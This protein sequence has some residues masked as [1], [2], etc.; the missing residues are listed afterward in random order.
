MRETDEEYL[1]RRISPRE[2]LSVLTMFP[3]YFEIETVNAC[4][5]RCPMCTIADWN[6]KDGAMK[7]N[8]FEKIAGEIE[9]HPEVLRVS[10]FRD[11]EPLLDKKLGKRI[12][13]IKRHSLADVQICTN[14]ELLD[15]KRGLEILQAGLDEC[16]LSIDSTRAATY[17]K[18]RVGLDH[19]KVM[20]NSHRFFQLRDGLRSKC[21]IRVRMI[22]QPLNA[23]EWEARFRSEWWHRLKPGDTVE[24][25]D[26]HNWGGQLHG[27]HPS[28][29]EQGE[30]GGRVPP[31]IALWSLMTIFANGDVPLC[32]VDYNNKFPLGNVRDTSIAELWQSASQNNRRRVHWD[33]HREILPPCTNC[34][35]WSEN[36][37]APAIQGHAA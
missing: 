2:R 8:L 9:S 35:V 4:Q 17:N 36:A 13:R 21:R 1:V 23:E 27:F 15:E 16:I 25:R 10:L 20:E 37:K 18:I 26:M 24:Y 5:A 33:G 11:G 34:T 14:V 12:A 7:D 6:R 31:C 22:R 3:R 19:A 28:K 32:N 30:K 29:V